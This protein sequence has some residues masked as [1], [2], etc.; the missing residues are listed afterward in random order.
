MQPTNQNSWYLHVTVKFRD[1]YITSVHKP[2]SV[3]SQRSC[4]SRKALRFCA[5]TR[6]RQTEDCIRYLDTVWAVCSE[7]N[8]RMWAS[9][10]RSRYSDRPWTRRPRGRSSSPRRGK[11]FSSPCRSGSHP[12][13]CP[14]GSRS[15]LP[16]HIVAG[17]W[18]WTLTPPPYVFISYG[19]E[20]RCHAL[21]KIHICPC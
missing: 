5:Y 19:Q 12:A 2:A 13:F 4:R 16:V 17:A 18:S 20:Q 6:L 14:M 3:T 7:T 11:I 9:R 10:Q 8:L 15:S 1:A 21:K